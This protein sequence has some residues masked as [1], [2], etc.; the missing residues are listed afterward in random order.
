MSHSTRPAGRALGSPSRRGEFIFDKFPIE[1][2]ELA[3]REPA[4]DLARSSMWGYIRDID[5]VALAQE[6]LRP[7]RLAIR[8]LKPDLVLSDAAIQV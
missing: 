4:Q 3:V 1:G 7:S 5:G 2:L 8:L 6:E